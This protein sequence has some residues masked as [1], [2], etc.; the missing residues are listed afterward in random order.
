[1]R[2]FKRVLLIAIA[3][4]LLGP[5]LSWVGLYFLQDRFLFMPRAFS[6]T[7]PTPTDRGM[8]Y[9]EEVWLTARDGVRSFA[10]FVPAPR[11][12]PERAP[13]L[14]WLH[15]NGGN[16]AGRLPRLRALR[17]H[18]DASVLLLDYRGYGLSKGEP[19]EA[20]ILTDAEAAFAHLSSRPGLSPERIVLYGR[21]MGG[22]V[23][24][25]QAGKTPCAGLI[26]E[27]TFISVPA[28][29]AYRFP[30]LPFVREVSRHSLDARAAVR[31]LDLP[32]LSI[33]GTDDPI[34]PFEQ[35]RAVFEAA[36]SRDK[37]FVRLDGVGHHDSHRTG[38]PYFEPIVEF[39]TRVAPAR[40]EKP[41]AP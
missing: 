33:H 39:V 25:I 38:A 37:R 6:A 26:L 31:T 16:I 2:W 24:A 40:L 20:G 23:A 14:L 28:M 10:W 7:T 36:Q 15:S 29:A 21:S 18:L 17:H 35:G 27:S 30:I 34:V 8:G 1:M 5:V 3:A 19:S 12:S 32:L 4:I 13:A 22:A 41:P 9:Y 11:S